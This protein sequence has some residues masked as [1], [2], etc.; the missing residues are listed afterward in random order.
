ME[1]Y[2]YNELQS[3]LDAI[4]EFDDMSDDAM[5]AALVEQLRPY[6]RNVIGSTIGKGGEGK[7]TLATNLAYMLAEEQANRHS[8][9]K[10]AL[11]VLYME[12]DA[13][14]DGR[15]DLGLD[16]TVFNDHGKALR[17][18]IT[19]D[20][21]LKVVKNVRPFLDATIS[22]K[23]CSD[24][25]GRI[26]KLADTHAIAAYLLL[27]LLLAQIS[28][29]YRWI[30]LDFSPGDKAI[31]RAGLAA[32]TH[33]VSPIHNTDNA[34]LRGLSTVTRL[35]RANRRLNPEAQLTAI[36]FLGFRKVK[37]E[38]TTELTN[39]RA[40]IEK[41]LTDAGMDPGLILDEYVRDARSIATLCR[42]HGRPAREFALAATGQLRD[43]NGELVP[44]PRD[45][46]GRY[47]DAQSSVNLADDYSNLARGVIT[48]VRQRNAELRE[49]QMQ[50]AS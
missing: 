1:L 47:V 25:A 28:H 6:L 13:N 36:A 8:Q 4:A 34:A 9:G 31:Q 50:G 46:N 20:G 35:I 21:P 11:P 10:S 38:A 17:D 48:R 14:G 12:I 32:S 44:R 37:G 43:E 45:E 2:E 30:V 3:R 19:H 16:A 27:A 24:I 33:L 42:N 5:L 29:L 40:K 41:L 18:A 26:N 22:G 23:H 39:V 49:K 15:T 7:T